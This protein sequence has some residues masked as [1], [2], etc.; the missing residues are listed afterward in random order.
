MKKKIIL[1]GESGSGKDYLLAGL[2]DLGLN[3]C[4]KTTTRPIR[5]NEINGVT[6]NYITNDDF[7]KSIQ[8][9]IVYQKF[10]LSTVE[11]EK[12]W[13][14]GIEYSQF[15]LGEISIMTPLEVNSLSEKIRSESYVIYV[16]IEE[17]IRRERLMIREDNNDSIDRRIKSDIIDFQDFTTYDT[18]ISDPMFNINDVYNNLIK[19]LG[20]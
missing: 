18:I 3:P 19:V 20:T 12:I 4:L 2:I 11:E 9:M 5:T 14:Y 10:D 1:T 15:Q 6:Y 8:D 17:N 7:L 16:C 13:Y